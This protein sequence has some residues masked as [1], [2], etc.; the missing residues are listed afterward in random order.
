MRIRRAARP[1]WD[2]I[3]SLAQE[4]G[5]NYA[6]MERDQFLVAEEGGRLG[7]IVAFKIHAGCRELCALG[8]APALRGRGIGRRLVLEL[9]GGVRGDVYLATIIPAFFEPLGFE[10]CAVVPR[11]MVKDDEWC[12]GCR[13]DLCAVMVRRQP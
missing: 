2:Q 4:C 9:V 5:L 3:V 13:R 10:R 6:G 7:G 8:V 11:S 1:D 12:A